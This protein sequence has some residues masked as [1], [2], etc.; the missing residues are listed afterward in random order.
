MTQLFWNKE[1]KNPEHLTLSEEPAEDLLSFVRW[2][3]RNA[4]WNPFPEGGFVLDIGCGNGRN[5]GN[6]CEEFKM[7]GLGIDISEEAIR[8]A[9][10][11]FVTKMALPDLQFKKGEIGDALELENESVDIVLDMMTMHFLNDEKRKSYVQ[12]V[13][14]VVKPFGW[15]FLK[16]FILDADQNAKRMIKDYPTPSKEHN[17]YIHPR[18]KV[19]EHVFTQDEIEDLFSPYFV[20]HKVIRSYKHITKDGKPHKRRTVSVYLER[21]RD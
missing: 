2:A 13:A 12:E 16:T 3:K 14:R 8:Q 6:V 19:Q 11:K 1:Y 4:E 9:R 17:S 18:L 10:D 7:G 21:K 5:I 20:V 15:M